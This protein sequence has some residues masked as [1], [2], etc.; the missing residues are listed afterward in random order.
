MAGLQSC[1]GRA[2]QCVGGH[3]RRHAGRH[4]PSR[5]QLLRHVLERRN[6]CNTHARHV[7]SLLPR[8]ARLNAPSSSAMV[9]GLFREL[10]VCSVS[11]RLAAT[12]STRTVL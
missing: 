4:L 3:R 11:D 1:G 7:G 6:I 8:G 5:S 12:H 2:A 9:G 10:C